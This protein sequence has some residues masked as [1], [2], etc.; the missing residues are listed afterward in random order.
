MPMIAIKD[1]VEISIS[2]YKS[3][4]GCPAAFKGSYDP[5]DKDARALL[6]ASAQS[7]N[8]VTGVI[9][10]AAI[11][12][13]MVARMDRVLQGGEDFAKVMSQ[14]VSLDELLSSAE[15]VISENQGWDYKDE[16]HFT[17]HPHHLEIVSELLA[18]STKLLD[19][20]KILV[21]QD[22]AEEGGKIMVGVEHAFKVDLGQIDTG[23]DGKGQ[24]F[25]IHGFL[26]LVIDRID[27]KKRGKDGLV[28][29]GAH[30]RIVDYKTG[31]DKLEHE[32]AEADPQVK[33]Y[34]MA[35]KTLFPEAEDISFELHY[36]TLG[37][38]VGPI[39]WT[40][41]LDRWTRVSLREVL[42][43]IRTSREFK[44]TPGWNC[45][46]CWRKE[47]CNGY[48]TVLKGGLRPI[49]TSN[50]DELVEEYSENDTKLE[51]I[52][53]RQ[54]ELKRRFDVEVSKN[55]GEFWAGGKRIRMPLRSNH[56]SYNL[57]HLADA[58][59]DVGL[60]PQDLNKCVKVSSKL[61]KEYAAKVQDR[62]KRELLE[63]S[64]EI[65]GD[66]NAYK[67]LEIKAMPNPFQGATEL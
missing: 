2:K 65:I 16:T 22:K 8:S 27:L 41:A 50:L 14:R 58:F 20:S 56:T 48:K 10:H 42:R 12:Q 67:Q 52:S 63:E 59:N 17:C 54:S 31:Y 4:L 61:V 26:S 57:N 15:K 44:E 40:P 38:K 66:K 60:D 24:E 37:Q 64:L 55:K 49:D 19:F 53:K 9:A 33:A 25:P 6:D 29:P 45:S 43:R 3:Y 36:T 35:A 51:L 11:E 32:D 62:V 28:G 5:A 46:Y 39:H 34:L 47:V 1:M 23:R 30:I 21:Y 18:K 13:A 7:D